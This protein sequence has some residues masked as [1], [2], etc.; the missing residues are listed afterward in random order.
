M[1]LM[2]AMYAVLDFMGTSFAVLVLTVLSDKLI[3]LARQ[4]WTANKASGLIIGAAYIALVFSADRLI[5]RWARPLLAM[6]P[7][8]IPLLGI[9]WIG[10]FEGGLAQLHVRCLWYGVPLLPDYTMVLDWE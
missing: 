6:I 2:S 9:S 5:L 1:D 3:P 4:V 10:A 7:F 8:E